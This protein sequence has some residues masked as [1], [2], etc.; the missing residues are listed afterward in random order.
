MTVSPDRR[1]VVVADLE[2]AIDAV[3]AGGL[4]LTAARRLVLEALLAARGPISAEDIADGLGGRM[5]QSDIASVY[6]NLETL[7]GLGLVRHFHAG[8]GPGRYVL[9]SRADREYLACEACGAVE[10]V[11]PTALDGVR[12]AVRELSGFEARFSHF[13]IVG[14]CSRCAGKRRRHDHDA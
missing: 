11:D 2:E 1:R 6:R 13:P 7:G 9:E 4:R 12:D 3:R 8:H 10:S 14:L 5:T